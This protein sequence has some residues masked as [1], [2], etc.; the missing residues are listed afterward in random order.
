MELQLSR[1]RFNNFLEFNS[2][3]QAM[4]FFIIVGLAL[5]GGV[6]IGGVGI[7]AVPLLIGLIVPVLVLRM[8]Y[9][10]FAYTLFTILFGYQIAGKGFAYLGYNPIFI[11]ELTLALGILTLVLM[12]FSS[13][14]KIAN[15]RW[16]WVFILII[17]FMGWSIYRTIPYVAE[18]K[19]DALR[20]AML[21]GYALYA[22]LIAI[23]IPREMV[24][25]FVQLYG[26]VLPIIVFLGPVI[27]FLTQYKILPK[28]PGAPVPIINQKSGDMGVH[29]GGAAAF[30]L[31]RLDYFNK[32]PY[33]QALIWLMWLMWFVAWGM[34][35]SVNRGGMVSALSAV[36]IAF[37]FRPTSGWYRPVLLGVVV[38]CM[39]LVTGT[40][41]SLR[42]SFGGAREISAEQIVN[43][44]ASVVGTGNN[45]TGNLE[46]TKEWRMNWW[47]DIIDYTFYG[48]YFWT[49]KGYGINLVIADGT[50]SAANAEEKGTRSPHNGFMTILSRS[51]VPGFTLWIVFLVGFLG[52]LIVNAVPIKKRNLTEDEIRLSKIA[53]WLLA[54]AGAHLVNANVDVFLEG[55][56]GGVWFWSIVGMSLVIF[57]SKPKTQLATQKTAHLRA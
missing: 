39:L 56:M 46:N 23:L 16:S 49:G 33:R 18:Y 22:F 9:K 38:L 5:I 36:A 47:N 21:Y 6:A 12:P 42:V 35:G 2:S 50:Y 43:N 45:E 1:T 54:Y 24:E 57:V 32:R 40:Y 52:T 10:L 44:L 41:S 25:Y 13:K 30:M 26:K 48:D 15:R 53:T 31:L 14:I 37:L 17:A 8:G 34:F 27:F 29:L 51:G 3:N 19:L 7:L 11:S 20:D 55:P 4:M 28:W